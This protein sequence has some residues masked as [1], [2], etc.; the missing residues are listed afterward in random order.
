MN[1]ILKDIAGLTNTP[2]GSIARSVLIGG[3]S[4]AVGLHLGSE[5]D[6]DGAVKAI[7]AVLTN[8]GT[9]LA[10]AAAAYATI[11]GIISKKQAAK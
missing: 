5:T 4:L 3:G 1:K 6:I 7:T 8:A 10:S 9:L 11:M 2:L